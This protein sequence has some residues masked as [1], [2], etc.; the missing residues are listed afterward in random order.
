M[1]GF[2][3]LV[4]LGSAPVDSADL[5]PMTCSLAHRGPDG[6]GTWASAD[7][8]I[9]LGHRR[10]AILDLHAQAGQPMHNEDR[11]VT[12]VFNGEIYNHLK[13]R[14]ELSEGGHFFSTHSADTEV[15]LHGYEQ[16][17]IDGLTER[18]EGIYSFILYDAVRRVTHLVRD[19]IGIKPLY[20]AWHEQN[21]ADVLLVG[22]ELR[23]ILA[24]PGFSARVNPAAVG[25]YLTFMAVPAP[26]T[27]IEGVFKLPAGHRLEVNDLGKTRLFRY[28]DP[29]ARAVR[30]GP[31]SFS[32][33]RDGVAAHLER[34]V[35]EQMI[36]DVPVGVMLSGGIDS[37]AILA[38]AARRHGPL[39]AYTVRFTDAPALDEVAAAA[40]TARR[41]GAR[42][43]VLELTPEAA[44]AGIDAVIAA[45]DEPQ[46]DWVCLPLWFLARDVAASGGKVVLVGE[47]ADELFAGY[48]H[49]RMYLGPLARRARLARLLGRLGSAGAR[50]LARLA[51]DDFRILTRLDFFE[52]AARGQELF[53]GGAILAWP[54]V[55][56]RLWHGV[57]QATLPRWVV[58][59]R[60]PSSGFSINSES[61]VKEWFDEITRSGL[62]QSSLGHMIALD[63]I[64]RLPELLLMRVDKMTMAHGVE[65]RVPF[66]DRRLVE[67]AFGIPSSI[68]LEGP[69][70]KWLLREAVANLVPDDLRLKPKIGFGA[71]VDRWLRGA[72]AGVAEAE[73]VHGR[74]RDVL[75]GDMVARAF[76]EH[77]TGHKNHAG[78]LWALFVLSRWLSLIEKSR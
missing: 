78:I 77:R 11:T 48:E 72:W 1:C 74:L 19:P 14:A 45:E 6:E 4:A 30:P 15:L 62:D 22:S 71:P 61:I 67:Y 3:G 27:V 29:R 2:A 16:W 41:C 70:P 26:Y 18:I 8:R 63:F 12:I 47:G 20:L 59:T 5:V 43:H 55:R 53:W 38:L 50:L 39:D 44:L 56:D 66:L 46:A 24:C 54:M 25:Q 51:P 73:I 37:S 9:A 7:R 60:T 32:E 28:F 31:A 42:H 49:W 21:S 23:A 65:A 69:Q 58:E 34:A 35:D 75:N 76:K 68:K 17:G 40:E 33:A 10:L 52:R 13:L 36:A 64:H 57:S